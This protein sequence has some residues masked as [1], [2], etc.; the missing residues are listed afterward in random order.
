[1]S[2]LREF[3]DYMR[4]ELDESSKS[5]TIHDFN[6]KIIARIFYKD[7]GDQEI[8]G[9]NGLTLGRWVSKTNTTHDQ[10]GKLIN[11]GNTLTMLLKNKK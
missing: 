7:N 8:S 1:M 4:G 6:G 5:E 11:R 9:F 10:Y 2:D 3:I